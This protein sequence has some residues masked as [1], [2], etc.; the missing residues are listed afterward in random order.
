MGIQGSFTSKNVR[1]TSHQSPKRK[2]MST[3]IK[4]KQLPGP[5]ARTYSPTAVF[6]QEGLG[7]DYKGPDYLNLGIE[8]SAMC[9]KPQMELW[10]RF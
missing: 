1:G 10:I 5:T 6:N 2:R 9:N 4:L 3:T 8:C 7:K